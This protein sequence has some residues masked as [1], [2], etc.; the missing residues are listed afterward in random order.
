MISKGELE[1]GMNFIEN[2]LESLKRDDIKNIL[3]VKEI[4]ILYYLNDIEKLNQKITENLKNNNKDHL[5]YNDVLKIRYDLLLFSNDVNFKKYTNAMHKIFQNKRMEA[6]NI[7]KTIMN[8]ENTIM[9]DRLKIDC[10]FLYFEQGEIMDALNLIKSVNDNSPFKENA[11][12]FEAEIY[13][14]I[15]NNKSKAAELYLSFLDFFKKSI[16][17]ES[18]RFRLRELAG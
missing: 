8:S 13:D 5:Y 2:N 15:L 9:N 4:Q 1:K 10:A 14:Y 11:I 16:Y 17:Y 7:L 12:I 6:I 3:K 18:V